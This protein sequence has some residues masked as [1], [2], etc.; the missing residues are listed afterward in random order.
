MTTATKIFLAVS[1]AGFAVG[2]VVDFCLAGVNPMFTATLPVG[3][4]FLGLFLISLILE[5]E[6]ALYDAEHAQK[7]LAVN[8]S[9][10]S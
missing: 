10:D 6:V 4:I 2:S 3:A 7:H 1:V 9:H 8:Q 5:K